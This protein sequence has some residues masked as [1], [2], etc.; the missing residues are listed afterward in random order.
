MKYVNRVICVLCCIMFA[1]LTIAMLI[2]NPLFG[3]VAG[4]IF[5]AGG[6]LL[7][8]HEFG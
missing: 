6:Y 5:L 3:I 4:L 2:T 1:V 7:Y 8:L